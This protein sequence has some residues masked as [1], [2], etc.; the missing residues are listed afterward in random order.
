MFGMLDYRAFQAYRLIFFVPNV[1][2]FLIAVICVPLG[3]YAIALYFW[4]DYF[5][6]TSLVMLWL[7]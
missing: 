5:E 7:L 3:S 4:R 1:I 2:L 6:L